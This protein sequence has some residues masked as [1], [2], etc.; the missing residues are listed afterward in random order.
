[1]IRPINASITFVSVIVAAFICSRENISFVSVFL[2]SF[3]ASFTLMAGNI[4]NDI[5]DIEI[6]KV[7]RPD[8][9][10]ASGTI[11]KSSSFFLYF[12]LIAASLILSWFINLY[13]LIIVIITTI[14][15]FL[16]SKF[17]KRIPLIGNILIA[18]LTGLV[19]IFGGV[20]VENASAAIIPALFAFLINLIREIVKDMQDVEGDIKAGLRTYPIKFGI[21]KSKSLVTI[22][23][24]ALIFTTLY[25]FLYRIYRIEFFLL[26]MILVNP[27]LVYC[28][29]ILYNQQLENSLNKISNLLKLNMAFGLIA[30]LL[31]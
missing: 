21:K 15:L 17:L 30:I 2:A 16:Y 7:N 13:A 18:F 20:A 23:I 14:L 19:F 27:I 29:K 25:P 3:T 4:I 8:R 10:L 11:A 6:D 22:F 26:V 28:L 1:M 24:I 5:Y 9:P 31:G 12:F